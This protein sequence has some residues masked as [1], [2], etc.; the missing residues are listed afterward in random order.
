MQ[1][2]HFSLLDRII[3]ELDHGLRTINEC[4]N[5]QRDNPSKHLDAADDLSVEEK[6]NSANLMRVNHAG[7]IAAQALY[8]GQALVAKSKEQ[9][10]HLLSAGKE[11]EDHLAWCEQRLDELGD[12]PSY[13]SPLWYA[14][15]FS[16]GVGAGLLGDALSLGFVEETEVQVSEHIDKHLSYLPANDEHSRAIL[17]Q[18]RIDEAAHAEQA[19][20]AGAEPLPTYAKSAMRQVAKV[21]TT[22][23]YRF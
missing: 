20:E 6:Q 1:N 19:R 14:G 16:I 8:R 5:T 15:S 9:R 18:M 22:L 13:L 21:M 23:S 4:N 2:R 17:E 3:I 11:E 7:E 12:R 10:E